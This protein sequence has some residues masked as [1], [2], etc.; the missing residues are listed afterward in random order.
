MADHPRSIFA[1]RLF[2]FAHGLV[3]G[4]R[5]HE[6]AIPGVSDQPL[7]F[8]ASSAV[9]NQCVQGVQGPGPQFE[10]DA[11]AQQSSGGEIHFERSKSDLFRWQQHRTFKF[12]VFLSSGQLL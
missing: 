12:A 1:Q 8:H 10:I 3:Y 5:G 11:V 7:V 9:L 4:V 2:D 6:G